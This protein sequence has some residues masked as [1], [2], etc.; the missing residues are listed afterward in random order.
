MGLA[1]LLAFSELFGV[2]N[3]EFVVAG[4]V[5]V[6]R[7]AWLVAMRNCATEAA[8]VGEALTL[9]DASHEVQ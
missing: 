2:V 9:S 4:L 7:E 1:T 3:H 5:E 8:V 6:L